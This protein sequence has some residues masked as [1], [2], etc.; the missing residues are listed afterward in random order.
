MPQMGDWNVTLEI[1][2]TKSLNY[3]IKTNTCNLVLGSSLLHAYSGSSVLKKL[4]EILSKYPEAKL[5]VC[6]LQSGTNAFVK[7][8]A[9]DF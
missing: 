2:S 6:I 9:A 5:N 8:L 7:Q 4:T 1:T 3:P